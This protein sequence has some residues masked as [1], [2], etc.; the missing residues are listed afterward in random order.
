MSLNKLSIKDV[1]VSGKTLFIRVDFNVPMDKEGKITNTARIEAA[2]P[3]LKF[4]LEKGAAK[5]V[6]CSHLGRP[7]G[8]GYEAEFTLKP[9]AEA[10]AQLIGQPVHF[11]KDCVGDEVEKEVKAATE[12]LVL[13]ENVR[14]HSEEE[15]KKEDDPA[16]KAFRAGLRK[17]AD[18]YVDDAFGTAH[19]AHSSM[20]GEGY[21]V[22]CAGLLLEKEINYFRIALE[23]PQRP[24][25]AILGGAKV[26]DKIQLIRNF[27]PKVNKLIIC[28]GMAYTFIK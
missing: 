15:C 1:N 7:S 10:L 13:L 6:L 28:G 9:V 14:F 19:R 22:R 12:K 20:V 26:S 23:D 3:T 17:L 8:K 16:V 4:A 18:I 11:C 24:Y 2:I 25:C 27:L 21:D 5:L